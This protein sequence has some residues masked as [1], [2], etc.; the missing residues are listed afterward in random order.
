MKIGEA[1]RAAE[2]KFATRVGGRLTPN[3]GAAG[4]KG[5][6]RRGDSLIEVKSTIHSSIVLHLDWLLK[7]AHEAGFTGKRPALSILFTTKSGDAKPNGKW[8]MIPETDYL[9]MVDALHQANNR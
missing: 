8:V 6:V 3:S 9:E 4:S 7:I 1:G 5:D 2:K